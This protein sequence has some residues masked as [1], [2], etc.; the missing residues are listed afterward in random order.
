MRNKIHH[1]LWYKQLLNGSSQQCLTGK[2]AIEPLF[3]FSLFWS[4]GASCDSNG[5]EK[6]DSYIRDAFASHGIQNLPPEEL[7][8]FSYCFDHTS[9]VWIDWMQTIPKYVCNPEKPFSELIVP[10]VDSV[11]SR[12]LIHNLM[13]IG[14]HVLCVGETGTGKTLLVQD[15]L[16]NSKDATYIPIFINFSARTSANQ[17]QDLLDSKMEKRRKGVYG[18]PPTKKYVVFVDDVNMPQREKYFAQPPIEILRQWMDH[19]GWYERKPPCAFRMLVDIQFIGCMGPPGGGRNPVTNR[20]LRHFNFLSFNEMSNESLH[21][22]FSTILN[23]TL[24]AKFS[25]ELQQIANPIVAGTLDI[26]NRIRKELLPTPS[27]SH[28]TFNLRDLSKVVQG[29]L[30]AD[31]RHTDQPKSM[32]S[33]WLH[34]TMRV[35]QDRLINDEDRYWFSKFISD[36]LEKHFDMSWNDVVT[37]ERLIF[38][39]FLAPGADPKIYQEV[40]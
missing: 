38:C 12:Y 2:Q 6:F 14:K 18:P 5:R 1:A 11:R 32:V 15:K 7:D 39:D 10:T 9:L 8:V 31:P 36:Q 3:V 19:K 13:Q 26:Y 29:I 27:K 22:I 21:L 35:F 4:V 40:R 24:M 33:L 20:F 28:Y 25:E 16:V 30:R 23:A 17:T 34:E 37:R